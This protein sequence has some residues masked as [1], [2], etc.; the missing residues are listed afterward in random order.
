MA[1]GGERGDNSV[2][3]RLKSLYIDVLAQGEKVEI[4][5]RQRVEI[6]VRYLLGEK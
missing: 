6:G 3:Y 4:G 5:L 1:Q 2:K